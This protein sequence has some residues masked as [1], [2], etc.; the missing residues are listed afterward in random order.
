MYILKNSI[1]MF[2]LNKSIK[3]LRSYFSRY[4]SYLILFTT[5]RCNARCSHCFYW[6]EIESP[7]AKLELGINEIDKIAESMNLIYLSL[8]GGEPFIRRDIP[9]IA[10]SFYDKSN[11]LYLNIVTNGFYTNRVVEDVKRIRRICPEIKIK[12]QISFDDFKEAH[13]SYRKVE[14]IFDKAIDTLRQLSDIRK[15]D[16]NLNVDIATCITKSNKKR[17][18]DLYD[19][20]RKNNDFDEYQLLYPRGNAKVEEE[21][22]VE[23]DQWWDAVNHVQSRSLKD[24]HNSILAAANRVAREKIYNF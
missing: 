21:K 6:E 3:F 14:G 22:E 2:G 7:N 4:P 1:L 24:N 17:V 12:I 23:Y 19:F 8:A 5:A 13:D 15:K 16:K 11:L 20:L 9:E 18:K 10:K